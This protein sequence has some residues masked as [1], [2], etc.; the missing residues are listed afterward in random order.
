MGQAAGHKSVY[1]ITNT[2][3]YMYVYILT[4]FVLNIHKNGILLINLYL[5]EP[6]SITPTG[7]ISYE[8]HTNTHTLN[9]NA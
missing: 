1:S 6:L 2:N 7:K 3:T 8:Y 4:T 5:L 9:K